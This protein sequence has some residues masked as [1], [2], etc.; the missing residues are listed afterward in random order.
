MRLI[1]RHILRTM[2]APFLWG[3]VALTGLML[4]NALPPLIEAFGGKGI[5]ASV[6]IE[7]VLLFVPALLALTLPMAVLVAVLYGYSQL[8]AQ[9]EMVAMYANGISVWRMA[10]PALIGGAVVALINFMVFDQLMPQSNARFAQLRNAVVKKNPTLALRQQ[11]LNVI[12]GPYGTPSG[13]VI[14]ADAIAQETGA[15]RGVTI[16]DMGTEYGT[17]RLIT[18]DSGDMAMSVNGRDL[19]LTLHSG[20]IYEFKRDEPGRL[21]QTNYEHSIVAVR[22]V[23]ND[24]EVSDRTQFGGR[25]EKEM[26]SCEL[27]DGITRESWKGARANETGEYLTRHDL[28]ALAG[29]PPV[30]QPP[31]QAQPKV[32]PHC[33]AYRRFENWIKGI[34]LPTPLAAQSPATQAPQGV[35]GPQPPTSQVP[36]GQQPVPPAAVQPPTAQ[37][38]LLPPNPQGFGVL[39]DPNAVRSNEY[40]VS[41]ARSATLIYAV[42]YHQ[43]FAVP[44][45]CFC[46]VLIGMALALKYP[47]SGIGLVIGGSLVIFLGFYIMLQG[48]KGVAQAGN[49]DP[50]LAMYAPVVLFTLIGLLAVNSADREMGTARS[51]GVMDSVLEFFQRFRR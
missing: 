27:L 15:M 44:L 12:P 6:M 18:A 42:E 10:R 46:F 13:Y 33:G 9:L 39:S 34:M 25:S 16:F 47:G 50:A 1:S 37:Q 51:A 45:A 28:R 14:R 40:S 8:A 41:A 7:G 38:F 36:Q 35:P 31:E 5:D 17:R 32:V 4:L 49:L 43:K 24:L 23:Q 48:T 30:M 11:V 21:Q 26:T 3:V 20:Q 22:N 19:V 29:L 2:A